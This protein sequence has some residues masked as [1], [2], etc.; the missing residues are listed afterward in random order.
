MKKNSKSCLEND[1]NDKDDDED[2]QENGK[3]EVNSP[4]KIVK[5]NIKIAIYQV[6]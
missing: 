4:H 3:I 2:D 5:N 6:N 1:Q